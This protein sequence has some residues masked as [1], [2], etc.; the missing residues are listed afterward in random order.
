M[1][2][3][4]PWGVVKL[5]HSMSTRIQ[6]VSEVTRSIRQVLERS[7]TR[8]WV[9][10]EV[11]NFR[12]Q[13]SGHMY[14]TLKDAEAQ[15]QCVLFAGRG[16]RYLMPDIRD[17]AQLQVF[18]DISVYPARGQYQMVVEMAQSVGEG[19]LQA[20]FE[21][22]KRRL[23][24]EGLFET[25]RKRR[26]PRVPYR[27]GV[28]TSPTG[29]ALRD[30]LNILGRR[31][32]WVSVVVAPAR[33]Q[34]P[35][36]AEEI[37]QGIRLLNQLH[38]SGR[39]PMGLIVIGRGGGSLEDLWAFNEEI[40]ARAVAASGLPVISA[41]GHEVDFTIADFV[42]DLRAPTPSAAAELLAPALEDLERGLQNSVRFLEN[43]LR[44]TVRGRGEQLRYLSGGALH[45]APERA[46]RESRQ[47]L[48]NAEEALHW[49]AEHYHQRQSERLRRLEE[50]LAR[51]RP[52]ELLRAQAE[53]IAALRRRVE[54]RHAAYLLEQRRRIHRLEGLLRVLGPQSTLER[55]FSITR[56]SANGHVINHPGE[57]P[58]GT[59]LTTTLAR[60]EVRS[61]VTMVDE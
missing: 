13:S 17:G 50:R 16:R 14:F 9:L 29:A 32:P 48:D 43:R 58:E 6:T 60:G 49:A 25:T 26:L 36:A 40:V 54:E 11:S 10:G 55:G 34:G 3:Q 21:E 59:E 45:R 56:L 42:A 35:G 44:E 4:G 7:F 8:I 46:L 27:V 31:A 53:R 18:G 57:A 2:E 38:A 51:F 61:R 19:A 39:A 15:L 28:V 12:K 41:V 47:R 37:V 22:L 20:R 24:A 23:Q 33:V 52:A 5:C 1:L 30:F